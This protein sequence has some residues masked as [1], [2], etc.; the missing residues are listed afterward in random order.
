MLSEYA[1]FFYY[2]IT[3]TTHFVKNLYK[4]CRE[5]EFS[6]YICDIKLNFKH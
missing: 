1:L 4:I 3:K 6:L 2:F 5:K